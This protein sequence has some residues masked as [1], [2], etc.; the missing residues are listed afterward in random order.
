MQIIIMLLFEG[1]SK[2]FP[3][4]RLFFRI[5][6]IPSSRSA[7]GAK[8]LDAHYQTT[9]HYLQTILIIDL[10]MK[11]MLYDAVFLPWPSA[12]GCPKS[13][14]DGLR[15]L[16][17][18]SRSRILPKWTERE[19]KWMEEAS[20]LMRFSS[21]LGNSGCYCN[22]LCHLLAVP[23]DA[24]LFVAEHE[25]LPGT[26]RHWDVD[27]SSR[28]ALAMAANGGREDIDLKQQLCQS[29]SLWISIT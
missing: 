10:H 14:T 20:E 27:F 16:R 9:P 5:V 26:P 29:K 2:Q 23:L 24:T 1:H 6:Q 11:K 17:K 19:W 13:K 8:L 21:K 28:A 12:S 3:V 7:I 25:L 4:G 15:P 18:S 22:H